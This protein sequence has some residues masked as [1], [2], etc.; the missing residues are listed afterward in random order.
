[1]TIT[2]TFTRVSLYLGHI[3]NPIKIT[4]RVDWKFIRMLINPEQLF[5]LVNSLIFGYFLYLDVF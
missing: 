5:L 4:C 3:N 1:M 2:Y